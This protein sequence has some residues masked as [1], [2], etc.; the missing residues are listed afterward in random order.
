MYINMSHSVKIKGNKNGNFPLPTKNFKYVCNGKSKNH[1]RGK[2]KEFVCRG[3]NP[4]VWQL[5]YQ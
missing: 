4:V 1:N 3:G 2:Y 5:H